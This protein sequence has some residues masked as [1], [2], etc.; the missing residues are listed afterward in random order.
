MLLCRFDYIFGT[1]AI[2]V[3]S[4]KVPKLVKFK[5]SACY[6]L[7]THVFLQLRAV[8]TFLAVQ[9]FDPGGGGD[10][11]VPLVKISSFSLCFL[12]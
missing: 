1:S 9:C 6:N 4:Q 11:S 8:D 7:S 3:Q 2:K 10:F 12:V 5:R